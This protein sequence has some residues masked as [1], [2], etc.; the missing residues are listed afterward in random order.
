MKTKRMA[1]NMIANI[2][3]FVVNAGISILLTPHIVRNLGGEAYGFIPLANNFVSYVSIITVALNSMASRFIS[4]EIVAKNH[5]KA[6]LYF[7]S[8]LIANIVMSLFLM[9]PSIMIILNLENILRIPDHLLSDVRMTF[10]FVFINTILA[11]IFNVFSIV[12]FA[13][14]RLDLRSIRMIQGYMIRVIVIVALFFLF[15]PKIYFVTATTIV[16]TIFTSITDMKYTK[17]LL[18]FIKL[19]W[20]EFQWSLVKTLISSGIWNS[21]NQVSS[22]LTST[23]DLLIANMMIDSV[24]GGQFA[25]VKTIPL[26]IQAFAAMLSNVFTPQFVILYAKKETKELTATILNSTKISGLMMTLPISFLLIMGDIFYSLW[27]PD[28]DIQ[29]LQALS[30][31]VLLPLVISGSIQTLF[32]IYSVTN[33]L[34]VP[35]LVLFVNGL[36]NSALTLL[37]L[38]YT[39]LDLFAIASVTAILSMVRDLVFTPV[40]AAKCLNLKWTTFYKSILNGFIYSAVTLVI[41]ISI[42]LLFSIESWSALI[43]SGFVTSL[44]ALGININIAFGRKKVN[45][46]MRHLKRMVFKVSI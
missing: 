5:K 7:N 41:V 23:I 38:R 3:S 24:A 28:E 40:Y 45:E 32:N 26:F 20:S 2:V 29:K 4:I 15:D 43:L 39:T 8:V 12:T 13:T 42:R 27:T 21:L 36:L 17:K 18:P 16:V 14:N 22:V 19:K 25:I 30:I 33:K 46:W 6:N 37:L 44:F 10:V 31:W 11:L 34:K 1:I 35:S 9:I